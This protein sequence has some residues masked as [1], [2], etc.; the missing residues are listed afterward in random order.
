MKHED[1]IIALFQEGVLCNCK[2]D[3]IWDRVYDENDRFVGYE[4][5]HKN[6]CE[7][8]TKAGEMLKELENVENWYRG[9]CSRDP[10]II[11][12]R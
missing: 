3:P 9:D 12:E 11:F 4:L 8:R 10:K 6:T 2:A 7:G 5:Q 1:F